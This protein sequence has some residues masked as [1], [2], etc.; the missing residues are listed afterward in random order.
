MIA[1]FYLFT[2]NHKTRQKQSVTLIKNHGNHFYIVINNIIYEK[3]S[4]K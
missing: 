3:V 1:V 4:Q 2:I